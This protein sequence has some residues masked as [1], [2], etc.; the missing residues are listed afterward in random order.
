MVL[1][2]GIGQKSNGYIQKI[3]YQVGMSVL[4]E[5]ARDPALG[6]VSTAT[7]DGLQLGTP[8]SSPHGEEGGETH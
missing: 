2:G 1:R 4:T 3:G 8:V 7:A 5:I 6:H